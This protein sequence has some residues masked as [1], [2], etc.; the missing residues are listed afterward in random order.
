MQYL[1]T[2]LGF[3][4]ETSEHIKGN[5]E[6][7]QRRYVYQVFKSAYLQYLRNGWGYWIETLGSYW[8]NGELNQR[9]NV[10]PNY[11]KGVSAIYQE[12]I[13]VLSW[14]FQWILMGI[15]NLIKIYAI[16]TQGVPVISQECKWFQVET[17][18]ECLGDIEFT[19]KKYL[20]PDCPN[21]VSA[22]YQERPRTLSWNF[23]AMLA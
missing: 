16:G 7:N 3:Q 19:Q 15:L 18:R 13:M 5:V 8:R 6:L 10:H 22:M 2:G 9:Q 23:Q 14:T 21:S 12:Q 11:Q 17:F 20:P 1:R 4:V